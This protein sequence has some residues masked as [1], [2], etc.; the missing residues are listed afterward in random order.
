MLHFY[1]N[2]CLNWFNICSLFSREI[3]TSSAFLRFL[4]GFTILLSFDLVI[5]SV[6]FPIN[7]PA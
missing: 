3:I 7:L 5:A 2:T 4:S 1:N 6:L